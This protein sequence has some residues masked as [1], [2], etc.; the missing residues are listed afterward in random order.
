MVKVL[1]S[2]AL[3]DFEFHVKIKYK[4]REYSDNFSAPGYEKLLKELDN[5]SDRYKIIN[6]MLNAIKEKTKTV[7]GSDVSSQID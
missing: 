2:W 5:K 1:E 3:S 6:A 4:G 7:G